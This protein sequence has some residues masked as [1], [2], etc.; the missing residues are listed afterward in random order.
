MGLVLDA[1][2]EDHEFVAAET[3]DMDA[4]AGNGGQP[5]GTA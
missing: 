4:L 2:E 3:A 1:V 5:F